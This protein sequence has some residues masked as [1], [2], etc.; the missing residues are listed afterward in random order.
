MCAPA[1]G[2]GTRGGGSVGLGGPDAPSRRGGYQP[3]VSASLRHL[4]F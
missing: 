4:I 1:A 2:Y 3:P